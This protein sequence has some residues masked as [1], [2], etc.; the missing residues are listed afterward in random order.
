MDEIEKVYIE[1]RIGRRYTRLG[2]NWCILRKRKEV[3]GFWSIFDGE[4]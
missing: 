2:A 1:R 3:R 4:L